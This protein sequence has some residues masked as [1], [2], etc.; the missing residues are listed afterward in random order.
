MRTHALVCV[1]SALIVIV[2]T[3]GFSDVVGVTGVSL[4]PS[5]VAAQVVSGIGFLGAGTIIVRRTTVRGLTTAASIW[6]VA[7]IGLACGAGLYP[8]AVIGALIQLLVL[9]PLKLVERRLIHH[10]SPGLEVSLRRGR[11][12][13]RAVDDAVRAAGMEVHT[14]SVAPNSTTE[15]DHLAI[16]LELGQVE[17]LDALVDQLRALEGVD[18]IIIHRNN[19][20]PEEE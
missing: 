19:R 6:F 10:T 20:A 4:D 18:R 12:R 3:Y 11:G 1:G 2:S 15:V 5:R 8:A 7:A 17:E 9:V 16:E 14:M 13:M